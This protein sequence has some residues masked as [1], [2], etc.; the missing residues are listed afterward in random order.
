M[1]VGE[2]RDLGK[3][4]LLHE[5]R[6]GGRDCLHATTQR[7][8]IQI[9]HDHLH[10]RRGGYL[11]NAGP[12]LPCT[13]HSHHA[14][15]RHL[16]RCRSPRPSQQRR[17]YSQDV[18]RDASPTQ[19]SRVENRSSTEDDFYETVRVRTTTIKIQNST[20]AMETNCVYSEMLVKIAASKLTYP[21]AAASASSLICKKLKETITVSREG[22]SPSAPRLY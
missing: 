7:D 13:H 6:Q 16:F 11:R 17:R 12:H 20:L 3:Q 22:E 4:L 1:T 15:A 10:L 19:H 8:V 2:E 5:S 21:A 9:R 18:P 14:D